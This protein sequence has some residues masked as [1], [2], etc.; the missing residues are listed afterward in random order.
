LLS[1]GIASTKQRAGV[2]F[3]L[4]GQTWLMQRGVAAR[5]AA[6]LLGMSAEIRLS[7]YGHHH[8][9]FLHG[10]VN[11]ITSRQR[12]SVVSLEDARERRQKA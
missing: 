10:A 12:V 2:H 9:G 6:G 4:A 3:E 1:S 8:P 7:T 11:A 5:E